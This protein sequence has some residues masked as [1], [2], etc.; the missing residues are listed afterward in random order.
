MKFEELYTILKKNPLKST[1]I[2][3]VLIFPVITPYIAQKYFDYSAVKISFAITVTYFVI[4]RV[5]ENRER[6][7]SVIGS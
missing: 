6:I 4:W 5:Y 1:L 7:L 2:I 3:A